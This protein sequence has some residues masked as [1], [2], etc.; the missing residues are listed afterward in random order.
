[1]QIELYVGGIDL[2]LVEIEAVE[3]D[4]VDRVELIAGN[5]S[6][7]RDGDVGTVL[8]LARDVDGDAIYG[9]DLGWVV[10]GE[11]VSGEGDLFRYLYDEGVEV[12]LGAERGDHGDSVVVNG[13]GEPASSAALGCSTS[14]SA[15]MFWGTLAL[16]PFLLRRRLGSPHVWSCHNSGLDRVRLQ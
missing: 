9:V 3:E 8:G 10:D 5:R 16:L 1:H 14:G 2:G 15:G 13:Y 6:R 12:E 7:L 11:L 4:A